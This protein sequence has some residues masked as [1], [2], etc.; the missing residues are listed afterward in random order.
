M[1]FKDDLLKTTKQ[2]VSSTVKEVR[3]AERARRSF[4]RGYVYSAPQTTKKSH[5][6]KYFLEAYAKASGGYKTT[7]RQVF[8]VLREIINR[9][10]NVELKQSDYSSFTQEHLT[11]FFREDPSLEN[12]ILFERRG[13]FKDPFSPLP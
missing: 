8:Y 13:F 5:I 4:N 10:E 3:R 9:K 7:A 12:N 11:H 2:I 1:S 6:Y